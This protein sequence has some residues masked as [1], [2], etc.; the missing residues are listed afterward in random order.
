LLIVTASNL[1]ASG[2]N[3]SFDLKV[4]YSNLNDSLA[5]EFLNSTEAN[6]LLELS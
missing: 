5:T 3:F 1:K 2:I 6:S 4:T